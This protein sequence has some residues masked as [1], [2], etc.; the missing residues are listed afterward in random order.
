MPE[1]NSNSVVVNIY[2]KNYTFALEPGQTE[3]QIQ[4]VARF[5]E[6]HMRQVQQAHHPQSPLQTAILAGLGLVDELFKLQTDYRAAES[7]IAQ[8]TSRLAASLGRVFEQVNA[9]SSE[10]D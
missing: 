6:D 7:D 9:V 5:V 2:G 10:E 1:A 4:R 3:E 8:R